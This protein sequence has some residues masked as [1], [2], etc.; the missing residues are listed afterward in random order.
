VAAALVHCALENKKEKKKLYK[1]HFDYEVEMEGYRR[2]NASYAFQLKIWS[3]LIPGLG[4]LRQ[5]PKLNAV[6]I[7]EA[8]IKELIRDYIVPYDYEWGALI[9]RMKSSS[10]LYIAKPLMLHTSEV[11]ILFS[12]SELMVL[13]SKLWKMATNGEALPK[14]VEVNWKYDHLSE[15]K[16]PI[17]TAWFFSHTYE[18]LVKLL[19]S[20]LEQIMKN[21]LHGNPNASLLPADMG[22]ACYAYFLD[23]AWS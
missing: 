3:E 14:F 9:E 18:K 10:E 15:W 6:R 21:K 7:F 17:R 22:Q 16:I 23:L 19:N 12:G 5:V 4:L 8:D 1:L 13:K 20:H 11:P 2:H